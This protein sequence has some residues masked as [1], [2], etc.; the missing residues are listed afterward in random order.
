MKAR[1]AALRW[2]FKLSHINH[3]SMQLVVRG[4]DQAGVVRLGH[5]AALTFA[6]TVGAGPVERT[7]TR[8]MSWTKA[9]H[10]TSVISRGSK[11]HCVAACAASLATP[12][13]CPT[14]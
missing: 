13:E 11:W 6:A 7:A 10:R 14:K 2:V 8:P 4:G 9:A 5:R 1:I 3:G 12:A